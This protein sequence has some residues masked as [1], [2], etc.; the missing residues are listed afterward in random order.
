MGDPSAQTSVRSIGRYHLHDAIAS[1]GMATVHVGRLV[2]P[3][4]FTRTVAIK[5]LHPHLARDSE[6]VAMFLDEAKLAAKIRHPNVVPTLDIVPADGEILLV[7]EYVHGESL[8]ALAKRMSAL[9]QTMPPEIASAIMIGCLH[10]LHAAHEARDE[11]G[12]LLNVVHRDVSPQNVLVGVDG[13]ARMIDFGVAKASGRMVTTRDGSLKGKLAYMAP[14]QFRRE[15]PT[16]KVDI[17]AAAIVFWEMLTGR[18][19]FASDNDAGTVEQILYGEYRSPREIVPTLPAALDDVLRRALSRNPSDR[20][21]TARDMATAIERV[22]RG[23]SSSDVAEWMKGIA[24]ETLATRARLLESVTSPRLESA[25]SR[26]APVS[27]TAEAQVEESPSATLPR[28]PNASQRARPIVIALV[29]IAA[30]TIGGL[31]VLFNPPNSQRNEPKP[32]TTAAAATPAATSTTTE[33]ASSV[34]PAPPTITSPAPVVATPPS[35]SSRSASPV[36]RPATPA[37]APLP[38]GLPQ[39]RN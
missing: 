38:K 29:A 9:G 8:S 35:A 15:E 33:P 16:P 26:V 18:R 39:D 13:V 23:A 22:V 3:A 24:G 25:I 6:F 34:P 37:R 28:A 1:G 4:G 12:N 36:R 31:T 10:G 32:E 5:R 27:A 21:D 2:G 30:L 17:Y 20:F 7:M 14:E 11:K 19:L